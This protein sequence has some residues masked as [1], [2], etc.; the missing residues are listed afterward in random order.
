MIN[1]VSGVKAFDEI[2]QSEEIVLSGSGSVFTIVATGQIGQ[3]ATVQGS[4]DA[5]TWVDIV[6]FNIE[7]EGE[8]LSSVLQFSYK[9]LQVIGDAEVKISRGSA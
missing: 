9:Y 3:S 2:N 1:L 8:V 6:S 4:I 5:E 7:A